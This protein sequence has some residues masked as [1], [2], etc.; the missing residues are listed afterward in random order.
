METDSAGAPKS[1]FTETLFVVFLRMVAVSCF[2]FGIEY[3]AMLVGFSSS[4]T[5]RFDLVGPA[6]RGAGVALAVVFPV[7]ALGLWLPASWG[8]VIWSC[9]ALGQLLMYIVW[10]DVF[11]SNWLV[12]LMHGLVAGVYVFFRFALALERRE[13]M[14]RVSS[15]LP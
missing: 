14:T 11:G 12:P 10:P 15:G 1:T 13:K 6:W 5:S 8:A 3:W 4:G 7:A 9:A 2:W